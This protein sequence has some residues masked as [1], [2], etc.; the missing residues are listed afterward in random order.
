MSLLSRAPPT[1]RVKK[2]HPD[3]KLPEYAHRD[4]AGADLSSVENV[5]VWPKSR[6]LVRTGISLDLPPGWYA[7]VRGRSGLGVKKG[8]EVG[9]G[10]IDEGYTGEVM[11]LLHNHGNEPFEV[12]AGDRIGQML[13]VPYWQATFEEVEQ[14]PAKGRSTAGFGSTGT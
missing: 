9:I 14:L 5:R 2:L 12:N 13:I 10:T 6:T 4:D 11:V 8:V 7:R 1:V 3:A